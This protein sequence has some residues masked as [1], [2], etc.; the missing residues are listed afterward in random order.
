ML[1]VYLVSA[2]VEK[3]GI[4]GHRAVLQRAGSN[5]EA[6]MAAKDRFEVDGLSVTSISSSLAKLGWYEEKRK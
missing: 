3:P 5:E 1:D 4:V 2:L 6:E